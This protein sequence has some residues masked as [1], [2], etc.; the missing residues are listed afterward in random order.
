MVCRPLSQPARGT[1]RLE[2]S[3]ALGREY[4]VGEVHSHTTETALVA[5]R[6]P[7]SSMPAP[8]TVAAAAPILV[9]A[10]A[11]PILVAAAAAPTV[12]S[13]A[14]AGRRAAM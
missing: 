13:A 8:A 10:A 2:N 4:L 1:V 6:A 9:T 7:S 12:V 5:R 3:K 11:A 14:A